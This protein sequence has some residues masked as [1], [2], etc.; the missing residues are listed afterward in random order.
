MCIRGTEAN[1][2]LLVEWFDCTLWWRKVMEESGFMVEKVWYCQMDLTFHVVHYYIDRKEYLLVQMDTDSLYFGLSRPAFTKCVKTSLRDEYEKKKSTLLMCRPE[3]MCRLG[4]MKLEC[5][6]PWAVALM[7]K[8][9]LQA[10]M[11][12][13][14][15][16]DKSTFVKT[17]NKGMARSPL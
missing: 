15:A 10:S 8:T 9:H 2:T 4:L 5:Q 7:S 3:D 16:L 12:S 11:D 14:A 1:I 13:L 6:A 17:S